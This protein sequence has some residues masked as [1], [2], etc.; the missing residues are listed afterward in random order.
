MSDAEEARSIML[1]DAPMLSRR[2][3]E[4]QFTWLDTNLTWATDD[5]GR[6]AVAA[7][8]LTDRKIVSSGGVRVGIFGLIT[9]FKDPS[10]V[11]SFG[12][13]EATAREATARLRAEGAEVVVP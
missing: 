9:D 8:S 12:D 11:S 13:L 3:E 1:K 2:I 5:D 7:A 4:S 10:Y 6:P